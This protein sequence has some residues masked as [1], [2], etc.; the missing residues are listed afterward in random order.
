MNIHVSTSGDM[1]IYICFKKCTTI[2][3]YVTTTIV[4]LDGKNHPFY[5]A[6][7]CLGKQQSNDEDKPAINWPTNVPPAR[8]CIIDPSYIFEQ[9]MYHIIIDR[10]ISRVNLVHQLSYQGKTTHSTTQAAWPL[11][12]CSLTFSQAQGKP[13]EAV[14]LWIFTLPFAWA[15]SCRKDP[16]KDT[17]VSVGLQRG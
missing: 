16:P 15:W 1:Y 13:Y 4:K 8:S 7:F 3:Q 11:S 5:K 2:W 12:R 14:M 17:L 10:S 6:I 9:H